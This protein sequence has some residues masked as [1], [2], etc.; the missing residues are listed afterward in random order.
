MIFLRHTSLLSLHQGEQASA[1]L[2]LSRPH[3]RLGKPPC[4]ERRL[5]RTRCPRLDAV[6]NVPNATGIV[7][8]RRLFTIFLRFNNIVSKIPLFLFIFVAPG[9]PRRVPLL[10]LL[11]FFDNRRNLCNLFRIDCL[12][13]FESSAATL[14]WNGLIALV[15]R[16]FVDK[17]CGRIVFQPFILILELKVSGRFCRHNHH[18][19]KKG[20]TVYR[21]VPPR[22]CQIH[23]H[24]SKQGIWCT[25][26]Y[27]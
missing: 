4:A 11:P 6:W 24:A 14:L 27:V 26:I 3:P 19:T 25:N 17:S 21:P 9:C 20:G 12:I 16:Q 18:N 8:A 13:H 2:P 7:K 15:K 22:Q 10:L 1:G 23:V 5:V